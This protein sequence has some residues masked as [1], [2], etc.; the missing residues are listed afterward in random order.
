MHRLRPV[1]GDV[2]GNGAADFPEFGH[3]GF[4][5]RTCENGGGNSPMPGKS[6]LLL[7]LTSPHFKCEGRC[8]IPAYPARTYAK[9]RGATIVA[10]LSMMNFFESGRIFP[11]VIFSLGTAPLYEPYDVVLSEI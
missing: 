5:G 8:G 11:Q 4:S 10:S 9:I 7:L 1:Y 2:S 3:D 6:V